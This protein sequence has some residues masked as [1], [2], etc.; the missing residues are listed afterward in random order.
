M[1]LRALA[2]FLAYVAVRIQFFCRTGDANWNITCFVQ[3]V[4]ETIHNQPPRST[5]LPSLWLPACLAEVKAWRVHLCRVAGRPNT[6]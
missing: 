5:C 1:R 3:T 2:N 6:V 4:S